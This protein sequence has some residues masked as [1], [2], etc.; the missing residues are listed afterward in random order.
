M[1]D[2]SGPC[3]VVLAAG[4]SRRLGRNKL[5]LP[6]GP[7][8]IVV[9]SVENALA[10]PLDEVIVVTGHQY[11]AVEE[12][13]RHL[14]VR[15]VHNPDFEMGQSTSLKAGVCEASP[16]CKCFVFFLGDQPLVGPEIVTRLLRRYRQDHPLLVA[17]AC[18]GKQGNPVLV[19]ARLRRELLTLTGDTGARAMFQQYPDSTAIVEVGNPAIRMDIDREEDYK[20]CL[21]VFQIQ[22]VPPSP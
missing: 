3:G 8:P 6:L 9:W 16:W 1:V 15:I 13:I 20:A 18:A 11:E 4:L 2:S 19:D 5:L 14:P 10:S 21:K 22:P 7:K 12:A 17:P